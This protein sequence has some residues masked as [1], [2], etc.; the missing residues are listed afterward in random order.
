MDRNGAVR[1]RNRSAATVAA[2]R[3][4]GMRLAVPE[5]QMCI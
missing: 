1:V 4:A 3:A 2:L 5:G